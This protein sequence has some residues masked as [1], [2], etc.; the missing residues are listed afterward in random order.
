MEIRKALKLENQTDKQEIDWL[1]Q[2]WEIE[3]WFHN[4]KEK[5]CTDKMQISQVND[6]DKPEILHTY[7]VKQE[8][9]CQKLIQSNQPALL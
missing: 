3:I 6:W 4:D 9:H 5:L 2:Y 7:L 8:N 1:E